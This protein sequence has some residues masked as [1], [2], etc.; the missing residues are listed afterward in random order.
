MNRCTPEKGVFLFLP[1]STE[2]TPLL[3]SAVDTAFPIP[4]E[5]L[6]IIGFFSANSISI[7]KP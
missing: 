5:A 4:P 2:V 6:T 7:P 3:A 1:Y